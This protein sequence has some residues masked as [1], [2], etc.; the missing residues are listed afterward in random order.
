MIAFIFNHDVFDEPYNQTSVRKSTE[1][2]E[3]YAQSLN[4][5]SFFTFGNVRVGLCGADMSDDYVI[6]QHTIPLTME[7]KQQ[8]VEYVQGMLTV[9][10]SVYK[11]GVP[12]VL[13]VFEKKEKEDC[14]MRA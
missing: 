7:Q 4:A 11:Q 5:K 3:T 9:K 12:N 10:K 6:V 1:Q 13:V 14:F 2:L 8:I